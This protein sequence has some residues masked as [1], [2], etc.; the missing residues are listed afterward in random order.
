[1]PAAPARRLVDWFRSSARP[2]P[3]RG[4]LPRDPY[5]VLL[6][7]VMAQQTQLDRVVPAYLAFLARF[8]SVE[9]LAAASIDEV[10]QAFTGLGYYR[11]ARSL[12][13]AAREVV[14][15]GCWPTRF[16]ELRRL[17]GLG[18]YTA[19]AVAALSFGGD[20]PPVDGNVAR[21]A[22]R[23]GAI[24]LP[25][26]SAALGRR[27]REFARQLH[28]AVP[29]PLVFEALME[30][31]AT[32]CTPAAPRCPACPLRA[33]CA[34]AVA[35]EPEAYPLP[36][37]RRAVERRRWVAVWLERADGLVLLARVADGGL[38]AGL[39]LPPF[40]ELSDGSR[41]AGLARSLAALAGHHGPLARAPGVSH[42]IT[43]RRIEVVPF[44]GVVAADRVGESRTG[45]G[46]H[47]PDRL[48]V[49]TSTLL[50]K[51]HAV[52]ASPRLLRDLPEGRS[53]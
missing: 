37:P 50:A 1:V 2:L 31:G 32:V 19:A 5:R 52:C 47:D 35:G 41:P 29:T 33:G 16:E 51:L 46:W 14:A 22:A 6:S 7:E 38:L 27:A 18:A 53:A 49:G 9:A 21:V 45:W 23:V 40:G 42:A 11:R 36:R 20:Q 44:V 25:L 24:A 26:G 12:H 13:E 28:A 34:A 3:W 8:P 15:A 39:W 30:L 17:P 4:D 10:L 43:H 48:T